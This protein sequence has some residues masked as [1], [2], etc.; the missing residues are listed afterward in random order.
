MKEE[1]NMT[2]K[3]NKSWVNPSIGQETNSNLKSIVDNNTNEINSLKEEINRINKELS[4]LTNNEFVPIEE[5]KVNV[6][7]DMPFASPFTESV[8]TN[9][10]TEV[11]DD[12]STNEILD[13]VKEEVKEEVVPEETPIIEIPLEDTKDR[14]AVVVNRYN[15]DIVASTRGKG[16]KFI[17]LTES[18]Q[19]K[20]L[21][22][23]I[24]EN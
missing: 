12:T 13:S 7:V 16:A 18:E 5:E 15:N 4:K 3:T 19:S 2:P 8:E 6:E 10:E 14:I 11:N 24:N 9:E 21:S 1:K 17:S 23:K 22:G 20:L